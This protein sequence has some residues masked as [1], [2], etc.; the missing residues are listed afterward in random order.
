MPLIL[1]IIAIIG[2][3]IGGGFVNNQL[4]QNPQ[5]TISPFQISPTQ[6]P[7]EVTTQ[8]TQTVDEAPT[9]PPIPKFDY[10][11]C[12]SKATAIGE[13]CLKNCWDE[14]NKEGDRCPQNDVTLN[15]NC[16]NQVLLSHNSCL[17]DCNS[18]AKID[19]NNCSFGRWPRD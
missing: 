6:V 17:S 8:E 19:M 1:A 10:Q 12:V 4:H 18:T 14:A 11:G 7:T 16:H 15:E 13:Q 9:S 2:A 5:P 3:F